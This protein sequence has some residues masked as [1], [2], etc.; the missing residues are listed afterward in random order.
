MLL[1]ARFVIV[2]DVNAN[3]KPFLVL[4]FGA[5][6]SFFPVTLPRTLGAQSFYF[7]FYSTCTAKV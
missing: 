2:V 3:P 5:P 6:A 1:Y 4:L 7:Y